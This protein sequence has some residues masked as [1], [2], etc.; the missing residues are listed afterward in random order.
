M[1]NGPLGKHSKSKKSNL[2]TKPKPTPLRDDD[3]STSYSSFSEVLVSPNSFT[4]GGS[5]IAGDSTLRPRSASTTTSRFLSMISPRSSNYERLEGGH[6]PSRNG[7]VGPGGVMKRFAWKKVAI[8][9]VVLIGLVFLFGPREHRAGWTMGGSGAEKHSTTPAPTKPSVEDI[10]DDH[11]SHPIDHHQAPP[12]IHED[13]PPQHDSSSSSP[14]TKH[15]TSFSTDPNPHL[16]THCLS[17]YSPTLPIVQWALMIDAGSTGSRIHIYKFN[18]CHASPSFE[19]EIF[20]QIHPGLSSF[21]KHPEDAAKSL[22]SLL[23]EAK[24]TVPK[25]MW[26]CTPVAVKA[27]AGL[28][29][30]PGTE[31]DE[32]LHTVEHRLRTIYPFQL[33]SKAGE[34]V[35]IMDGK[36]EGVYAWITANYLLG[37]IGGSVGKGEKPTYAVLDLGGGSTQIVFEPSFAPSEKV[38]DSKGRLEDGEHKYTLSFAGHTYTLYQH[39]YLG[40]GLMSARKSVHAL[41]EFMS[42]MRVSPSG[43]TLKD[44]SGN[45]IVANAC[46]G[47]GMRRTIEVSGNTKRNVTMS[48]EEISSFEA[49]SKI[50]QLVLA[51]DSVCEMKPCSFNGVYQPSLL[52][53]FPETRGKVLLLSYFYDRVWP[54]LYPEGMEPTKARSLQPSLFS[55]SAPYTPLLTV[56]TI[57][58]LATQICDGPSVYSKHPAWSLSPKLQDEL[59]GRP[60]WCLDLTF[61]YNLLRLGYEW[62][63]ERAVRVEKQVDG[64]ELGW[65]LGA[66]IGLVEGGAGA[67][68]LTKNFKTYSITNSDLGTT[69]PTSR[70]KQNIGDDSETFVLLASSSKSLRTRPSKPTSEHGAEVRSHQIPPQKISN[71]VGHR[72]FGADVKVADSQN[73]QLSEAAKV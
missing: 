38:K 55:S 45:E 8:A 2:R 22:D 71:I 1:P 35:M 6:G 32:I 24:K 58:K 9:A 51:K 20:Q 72:I 66:A 33:S 53:S 52:D 4:T 25:S 49:C 17:P 27:T 13:V 26:G 50:V 42:K 19:Y 41:V 11:P 40:Y 68:K 31:A 3:G 70:S 59:D 28:R 37:T 69:S 47:R 30:L 44:A 56:R 18:N 63:D 57:S 48:G 67:L 64:T 5:G 39:S 7:P 15:P 34:G 29:L 36:E 60:E 10:E 14:S 12:L 46:L 23:D 73:R 65:C 62:G 21:A 54:L 61:M 43:G 16:T